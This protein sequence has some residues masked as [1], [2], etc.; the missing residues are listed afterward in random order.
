VTRAVLSDIVD[1]AVAA[2]VPIEVLFEVTHRCNL[3]CKHCYLP[4]H[5]DHGELTFA[6]IEHLLDELAAAGTL[7]LTLTGGEVL[8]RRDFCDIVDAAAARGFA[9]KILSNA[10]M[11]T[12]EIARRWHDAGVLEVSVSIYGADAATHDAVTDLPGSFARTM[13]GI[14][15]LRAVGIKVALKTPLMTLNGAGAR[16]VHALARA[17]GMPCRFD[18]TITPKNDGATGPLALQL[19]HDAL[20]EILS[21]PPFDVYAAGGDPDGP[22]P[23]NAGRAYCAIGPTGDLM[24]CIMMP[25]PVGSVRSTPFADLWQR[26]PLLERLR[27]LGRA[28]LHACTNCDVKAT[29]TRC[30]GLAKLRGQDIDGCD[31]SAKAVA[32]ARRSAQLRILQG[33]A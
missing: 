31:L 10:T 7:F 30:P 1:G 8:S 3:P 29:C 13:A 14:E 32:R 21:K 24:P 33:A 5:A 19:Q 9:V 17:A 15:R 16:D 26:A 6:E 20:V 12:D 18:A 2:R 4:D 23:C 28:D 11:V 27:A 25:E 22:S